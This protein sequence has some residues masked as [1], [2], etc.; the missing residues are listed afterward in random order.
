V[1][2]FRAASVVSP[3]S[4]PAGDRRRGAGQQPA[5]A[6]HDRPRG[7]AQVPPP[8]HVVV[9]AERAH[10]DDPGALGRVGQVVGQHRDLHPE[11]RGAHGRPEQRPITLI[12]R[13]GHQR[14]AGG[15]QFGAGCSHRDCGGVASMEGDPVH[16]PG[17]LPV[18]HL[19]LGHRGLE[20]HVPQRRRLG[21]VGL[22]PGEVAQEGPLGDGPGIVVDGPVHARPVHRKPEPPPHLLE[23]LL[24]QVGQPVAEFGEVA[25]GYRH[26]LGAGAGGRHE[27]G[28]KGKRRV[29]PHVVVVLH[30]AFGRQA[31][32]V[33]AD[34]VEH[35]FAAHALKP[36]DAV[37]LGEREDVPDVQLS[38]DRQ[39]GSV[40]GEDVATCGG[41]VKLVLRPRLPTGETTCPR[42]RQA[43]ACP[44]RGW[45]WGGIRCSWRQE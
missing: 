18:L 40:N 34:R 13:V 31:V 5:V 12:A 35:L 36:R 42:C 29:T 23:R 24:V 1:I 16:G 28:I 8:G 3:A 6:A 14:H 44:A 30:P 7:Q 11:Q 37:G 39:R 33:P 38:A 27:V 19:G 2:R 41:A 32:V 4:C 21:Q 25:A 45:R 17:H 20:R 43:K 10:H 22:A 26:R 9:V 15:E